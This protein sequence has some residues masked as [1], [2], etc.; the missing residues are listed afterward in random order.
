[1]A[2][3]EQSDVFKKF[4]SI[5]N[6]YNQNGSVGLG[7]AFCK[8]LVNFM[9]GSISGIVR[10]TKVQPLLLHCPWKRKNG[11]AYMALRVWKSFAASYSAGVLMDT[12]KIELQKNEQRN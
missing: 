9:H 6:Q 4:Y 8:E 12:L 7:L 11:G 1:M 2:R 10:L 5:E 3:N